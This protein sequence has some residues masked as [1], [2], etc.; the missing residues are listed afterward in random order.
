MLLLINGE[1]D[2][3]DELNDELEGKLELD[4]DTILE[5]EQFTPVH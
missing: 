3:I 4:D 2:E 5:T 1:T